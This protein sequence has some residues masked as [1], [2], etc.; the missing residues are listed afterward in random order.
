MQSIID[1]D[2][3]KN[4]AG[5]VWVL[6][7]NEKENGNKGAKQLIFGLNLNNGWH[8]TTDV[9]FMGYTTY[10]E[11]LFANLINGF[12]QMKRSSSKPKKHTINIQK[13]FKLKPN[14]MVVLDWPLALDQPN[15][16]DYNQASVHVVQ[17]V[18][19]DNEYSITADFWRQIKLLNMIKNDIIQF[20][21][22]EDDIEYRWG[23]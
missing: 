20:K 18:S 13:E 9:Q 16:K 22:N 21:R 11:K 8:T 4:D 6:C 15:F 23:R 1:S 14:L 5:Y 7:D 17:T 2:A 3:C 10:N 12:N 19:Y